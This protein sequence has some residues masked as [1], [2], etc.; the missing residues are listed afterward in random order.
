[1]VQNT[2]AGQQIALLKAELDKAQS[3]AN[4]HLEGWQRT[5]AELQRSEAD[6]AAFAET[7][8]QLRAELDRSRNEIG[9][10]RS[11]SQQLE[12]EI[13]TARK[14]GATVGA[15]TTA[16]AAAADPKQAAELESLRAEQAALQGRIKGLQA[17][18]DAAR[19]QLAQ[20]REQVS[21]AQAQLAAQPAVAGAPTQQPEAPAPATEGSADLDKA[22]AEAQTNLD[23]WQRTRAEFANY[24]KRMDANAADIKQFA[25][26]GLI[27]KLL[28]VQDDFDRAIKNLP[29]NLKG[30][31]WI[32]GVMLIAR[33]VGLT[34]ESEGAKSIEVNRG[35]VFDPSIHEAV[36]H[37]EDPEVKSG[38]VIEELQKGYK[39]GERVLRPTLVRVAK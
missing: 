24:K 14:A 21:A 2:N 13:N 12:N 8:Q 23:G 9:T 26:E 29:E 19:A 35:D 34:L 27:K 18:L 32:E 20:A 36:T 37:D 39:I 11:R 1:M 16:A 25:T 10:L 38:H 3:T 7:I 33:K 30:D 5:Y 28:P 6:A 31:V 22:K 15:A 4:S 17:E